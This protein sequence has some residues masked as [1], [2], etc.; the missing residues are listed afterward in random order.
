MVL[1]E[2]FCL[3]EFL[4]RFCK[5]QLARCN[6]YCGEYPRA[7]MYLDEYIKEQ[8]DALSNQF[9]FLSEVHPLML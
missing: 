8:P 2:I 1:I 9:A 7:L 3:K 6:Y 5:L 4:G